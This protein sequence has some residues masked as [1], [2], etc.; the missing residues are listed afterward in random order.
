VVNLGIN[1]DIIGAT[2]FTKR[3]F[4]L[5]PLELEDKMQ[6]KKLERA[7]TSNGTASYS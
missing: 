5:L 3:M 6:D 4:R 2:R 1:G 7:K